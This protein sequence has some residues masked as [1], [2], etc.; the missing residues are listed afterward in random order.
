[1]ALNQWC[2]CFAMLNY[3]ATIFAEAGSSL[4][5]N[6]SAIVVAV[7]QIFGACFST[8]VDRVGRKILLTVS[9]FGTSIGLAVLGTYTFL[10]TVDDINLTSFTWVP[11]A[12]FSFTIFIVSWGVLTLPFLVLSEIAPQKVNSIASFSFS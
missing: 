10:K 2:G 11:L 9:A 8:L 5:P 1:M 4:S 7:I 12:S 3:T 6:L